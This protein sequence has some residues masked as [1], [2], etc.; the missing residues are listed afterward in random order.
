[1]L[2]GCRSRRGAPPGV[3]ARTSIC[4][5]PRKCIVSGGMRCPKLDIGNPRVKLCHGP[6]A[7]FTPRIGELTIISCIQTHIHSIIYVYAYYI[8]YLCIC[9]G[10]NEHNCV[11]ISFTHINLDIYNDGTCVCMVLSFLDT[12]FGISSQGKAAFFF[13]GRL[14]CLKTTCVTR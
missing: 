2:G 5:V 7:C 4:Q 1:M 6:R 14:P 10:N 11:N 3:F 9:K 12:S 8:L 13:G